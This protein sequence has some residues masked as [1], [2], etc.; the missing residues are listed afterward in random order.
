MAR[1]KTFNKDE[2]LE[3]ALH[4]FWRKGYDAT[5]MQDLVDGLGISR[6]SIYDT[7]VDKR[8]LFLEALSHY[9]VSASD[10]AIQMI[11]NSPNPK[12]AFHTLFENSLNNAVKD[13]ESKGCFMTN[14]AVEMSAYDPEISSLV[15]ANKDRMIAAF[16]KA[17]R[18][19][20]R[21][22]DISKNHPAP[23]LAEF[24]FTAFNGLQVIAKFE[25]DKKVLRKSVKVTLSM[26]D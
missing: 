12:E 5:S 22:G 24:L 9:R 19:G 1:T 21:A 13:P 17:I 11:E 6:S 26:L 15:K 4:L 7:F 2:V 14:T 23:Y 16:T 25:G 10:E 8:Q 3:K 18:K 20:Q